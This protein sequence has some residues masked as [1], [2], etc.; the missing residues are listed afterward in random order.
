MNEIM[1]YG[2]WWVCFQYYL[3][4]IVHFIMK[5][6]NIKSSVKVLREW[7]KL[8]IVLLKQL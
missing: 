5:I 3:Y 8:V 7:I 4:K 6:Y 2:E 1:C